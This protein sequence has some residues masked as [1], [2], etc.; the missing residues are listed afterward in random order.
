M[1]INR[2]LCDAR[3]KVSDHRFQEPVVIDDERFI[4]KAPCPYNGVYLLSRFKSGS[5]G[6]L[7]I[8]NDFLETNDLRSVNHPVPIGRLLH[9]LY[10]AERKQRWLSRHP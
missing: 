10:S 6:E 9:R 4:I 2:V 3:S 1:L 7:T 5:L 8:H